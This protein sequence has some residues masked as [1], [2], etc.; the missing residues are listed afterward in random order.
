[1]VAIQPQ[2]KRALHESEIVAERA[3]KFRS[4]D[5][6]PADDYEVFDGSK[7]T[8]RILL[9]HAAPSGR[10]RIW[11]IATGIPQSTPNRGYAATREEAMVN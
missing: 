4:D 7:H 6:W 9:T 11:K 10:R 5:H 1:M 3:S 2:S 8:G